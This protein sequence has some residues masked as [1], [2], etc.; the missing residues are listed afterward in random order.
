MG[1]Q[2][3]QAEIERLLTVGEHSRAACTAFGE[4]AEHFSDKASLQA[5]LSVELT[6]DVTCLIKGSRFMQLDKLADA[7]S[8]RG[9][10]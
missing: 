1:Q 10:G 4:G 9:E 8:D 2:V 5:R 3:K 7:L 6:S